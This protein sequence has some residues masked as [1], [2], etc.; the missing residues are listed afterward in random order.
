[1]STDFFIFFGGSG[2]RNSCGPVGVALEGGGDEKGAAQT[3]ET[4]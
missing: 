4:P 2:D 3:I 1:L